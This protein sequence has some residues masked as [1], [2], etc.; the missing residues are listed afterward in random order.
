ME[1]SPEHAVT[2]P[3][4]AD[5]LRVSID[6]IYRLARTGSIP[7]FRV[8]RQWRFYLSKVREHAEKPRD[9]WAQP[10]RSRA[11]KRAA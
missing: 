4:L 9:K 1:T 7:A 6:T 11:R 8:G 5:E 2:A 3:E 10:Q